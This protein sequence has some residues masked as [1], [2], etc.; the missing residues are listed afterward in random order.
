MLRTIYRYFF[1]DPKPADKL[2]LLP[3][4][5]SSNHNPGGRAVDDSELKYMQGKSAARTAQDAQRLVNKHKTKTPAQIARYVQ[6]KRKRE[7]RLSRA[8]RK[9]LELGK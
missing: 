6:R 9:F 4:E 1:P 3:R 8:W 7:T 2:P 5:Y